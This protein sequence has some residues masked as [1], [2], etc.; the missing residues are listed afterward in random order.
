VTQTQ[1]SPTFKICTNDLRPAGLN[2]GVDLPITCCPRPVSSFPAKSGKLFR[3][4]VNPV[5]TSLSDSSESFTLEASIL[6]RNGVS[7][8]VL[9]T[10]GCETLGSETGLGALGD[11][12]VANLNRGLQASLFDVNKPLETVNDGNLDN[13]VVLMVSTLEASISLRKGVNGGVLPTMGC[14]TG[15]VFSWSVAEQ[16]C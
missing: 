5:Q 12:T 6:L 11:F 2:L 3:R 10:I 16:I 4:N 1:W 7:G 9:P 15:L 13:E 8:F 14:A